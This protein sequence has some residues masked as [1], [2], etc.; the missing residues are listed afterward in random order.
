M[1][2]AQR[3]R[4]G[5]CGGLEIGAL[6]AV[7]MAVLAAS[8]AEAAIIFEDL[9][10]AAPP[11][12]LGG[13]PL[14]SFPDDLGSL[15]DDVTSAPGPDGADV[16]FDVALS[17][18]EVGAGWATWSHGYTGDV[19]YLATASGLHAF[20]F[21]VGLLLPPGVRA[22]YLYAEPEDFADLDI[23]AVDQNGVS[24]AR[25]VSGDGGARGF[26]FYTTDGDV[27]ATLT[28]GS[29]SDFAIGEFGV[30]HSVPEPASMAL[31]G[32]GVLAAAS[33]W[34][35]TRLTPIPPARPGSVARAM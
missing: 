18:R 16:T 28:I 29:D 34:R 14:T 25:T 21:A 23:V 8:P 24:Y 7:M 27:L 32:L 26:G 12:T 10:T 31:M 17:H 2:T 1:S 35:R 30:A 33:R 22:F 15:F 6:V 19:Y 11:A 5:G 3:D 13:F 4:S 9:G 20:P